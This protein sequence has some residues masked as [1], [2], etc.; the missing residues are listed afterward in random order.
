M[1][2]AYGRGSNYSRAHSS[3]DADGTDPTTG[4]AA[5][6]DFGV[7]DYTQVDIPALVN[8]ILTTRKAE[9]SCQ[10]VNLVTH[11][12]GG[13]FSLIAANAFPTTTSERVQQIISNV[14]CFFGNRALAVNPNPSSDSDSSS[15]TNSSSSYGYYY[16]SNFDR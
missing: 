13:A 8:F 16:Q 14:P 3:L 9:N 7:D 2:I 15:D 6:W 10:K 4:A 1:W 11:S 5:Y 12:S